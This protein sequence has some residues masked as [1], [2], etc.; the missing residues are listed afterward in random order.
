MAES[1][2]GDHAL[3]QEHCFQGLDIAEKS[4]A[5]IRNISLGYLT[6]AEAYLESGDFTRSHELGMKGLQLTL[7][8][9]GPKHQDLV[10]GLQTLALAEIKQGKVAVA[11]ATARKALTVATELFGERAAGTARPARTLAEVLKTSQPGSPPR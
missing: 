1:Y 3:A 11:Q 6:L 8:I 5:K 4:N 10:D 2:R 7:E 9:F